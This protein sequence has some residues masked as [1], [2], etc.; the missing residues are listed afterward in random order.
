MVENKASQ[1]DLA[2]AKAGMLSEIYKV[3]TP[4]TFLTPPPPFAEKHTF[5]LLYRDISCVA[6]SELACLF[7]RQCTGADQIFH[8]SGS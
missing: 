3:C 6:I 8:M 2:R 1:E 5:T 4:R 7:G